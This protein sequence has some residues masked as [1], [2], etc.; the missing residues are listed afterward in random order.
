MAGVRGATTDVA[1]VAHRGSS[2]S[3]PENTI[4]AI[5][6]AVHEQATFVEVDVQRTAD[7]ELVVVHDTTLART[8]DVTRVFPDRAPWRVGEFTRAELDRLDAGSWYGSEFLGEPIPT[9]SDVLDTIGGVTGL[10]LELKAPKLYPGIEAQIVDELSTRDEWL[11]GALRS[12]RLVVQS[13]RR[14][15]VRAFA[16]LAPDIPTALLFWRRPTSVELR[17]ASWWV[18]QVNL[19]HRVADRRLVDQVHALGMTTGL[20]TVNTADRMHDCIG[21]GADAVITDHPRL[22]QDVLALPEAS[23]A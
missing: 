2:G 20:Y 3:A 10:L 1:V 8:T 19:S 15:S 7:G 4:A 21:L 23:A 12:D 9:L 11:T 18:R 22:L 14:R 17:A 5:E 16:D 13:F 6:L